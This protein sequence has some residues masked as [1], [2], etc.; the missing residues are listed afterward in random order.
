MKSPPMQSPGLFT[1]QPVLLDPSQS[2][3]H[4]GTCPVMR[5]PE[6]QEVVVHEESCLQ[7][8]VLSLQLVCAGEYP[9]PPVCS[10]LMESPMWVH[11][12]LAMGL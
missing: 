10:Q 4:W 3:T 2:K 6:S 5:Y 12:G 11:L 1:H 7:M 9:Y 8:D